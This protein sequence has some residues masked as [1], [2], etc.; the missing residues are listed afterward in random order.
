MKI[1]SLI[2]IA[3]VLVS[4]FACIGDEAILSQLHELQVK[5]K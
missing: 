1:G 3:I 4:I 2:I 5:E